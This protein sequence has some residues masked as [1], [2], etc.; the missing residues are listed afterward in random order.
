MKQLLLITFCVAPFF[1][2]AQMSNNTI[3]IRKIS[4]DTVSERRNFIDSI[5]PYWYMNRYKNPKV[6]DPRYT[7]FLSDYVLVKGRRFYVFNKP[8]SSRDQRKISNRESSKFFKKMKRLRKRNKLHYFKFTYDSKWFDSLNRE[9]KNDYTVLD[10][11][12]N[13]MKIAEGIKRTKIPETETTTTNKKVYIRYVILQDTIMLLT[14]IENWNRR[15]FSRTTLANLTTELMQSDRKSIFEL[16]LKCTKSINYNTYQFIFDLKKSRSN[17]VKI[18]QNNDRKFVCNYTIKGKN[19]Y[20]ENPP[21]PEFAMGK[22]DSKISKIKFKIHS[23]N[24]I[25]AISAQ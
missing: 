4:Y 9:W 5:S 1:L 20:I 3:K 21:I 14:P 8:I 19:I 22:I 11:Y 15:N 2:K 6:K 18:L 17:K 7:G 10:L 16:R 23:T 25:Y 24:H 13:N 12:E